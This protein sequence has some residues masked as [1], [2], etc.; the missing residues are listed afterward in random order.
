MKMKTIYTYIELKGKQPT[1]KTGKY[2]LVSVYL[3]SLI[4]DT[5]I[6][7]RIKELIE[8]SK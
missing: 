5:E 8:Y 3:I 2:I 4:V 1:A 7:E 6:Q